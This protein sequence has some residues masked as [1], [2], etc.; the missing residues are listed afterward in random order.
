[1][2]IF[3]PLLL[4]TNLYPQV[5]NAVHDYTEAK[6]FSLG[7]FTSVL[8]IGQCWYCCMKS[9]ASIDNAHFVQISRIDSLLLIRNNWN[10][11]HNCW[12]KSYRMKWNDSRF[13]TTEAEKLNIYQPLRLVLTQMA[14]FYYNCISANYTSRSNIYLRFCKLCHE[15]ICIQ[16][17]C[18]NLLFRCSEKYCN[19]QIVWEIKKI[20]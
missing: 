4:L 11:S 17:L 5:E 13:P 6:L 16:Q 7:Y 1:M 9:S 12:H 8:A 18:G 20:N 10:D 3:H 14:A 15:R 2:V 19:I